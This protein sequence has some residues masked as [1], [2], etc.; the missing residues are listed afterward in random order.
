MLLQAIKSMR[1]EGARGDERQRVIITLQGG[2]VESGT[3]VTDVNVAPAQNAV[4]GSKASL[5][6]SGNT[7]VGPFSISVSDVREMILEDSGKMPP[8]E[9]ELRA[10]VITVDGKRF[11]LTRVECRGTR[12]LDYREGRRRRFVDLS[13]V[14][15][16]DFAEGSANEE[17]RPVT[18]TYWTGKTVQGTV[19]ASRVRLS[20]ETDRAF[21]ERVN[22]AWTGKT[23]LGG[24]FSVGM[25]AIKQIRFKRTGSDGA[26]A[27]DTV[28]A[29][30]R[31]TVSAPGTA[32]GDTTRTIPV[33]K[34]AG[35][36]DTEGG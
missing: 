21:Y 7:E 12:R 24:G 8:P 13:K 19:E 9:R 16:I 17:Q 36:G 23:S 3:M 10:T 22:A 11:D 14:A 25:H 26:A 31:D 5:R 6:F 28:R 33:E 20:G 34:D 27:S 35:S 32:P 30:H 1:F 29:A 2:R 4:G 15:Q 18:I